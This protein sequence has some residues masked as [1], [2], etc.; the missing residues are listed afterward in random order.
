MYSTNLSTVI[1]LL[2]SSGTLFITDTILL[3]VSFPSFVSSLSEATISFLISLAFFF[4]SLRALNIFRCSSGVI[5]KT[6]LISVIAFF[7]DDVLFLVG[8]LLGFFFPLGFCLRTEGAS[9]SKVMLL[10]SA[11]FI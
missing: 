2:K 1:G 10:P 7:I 9:G 8:F 11:S 3:G 4:W 5:F 6:F